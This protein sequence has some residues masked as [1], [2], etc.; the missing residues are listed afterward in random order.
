MHKQR[1]GNTTTWR[2]PAKIEHST[3]KQPDTMDPALQTPHLRDS[4]SL[5]LKELWTLFTGEFQTFQQIKET[6]E[7]KISVFEKKYFL[8]LKGTYLS[9]TQKD[10]CQKKGLL[11][12]LIKGCKSPVF[13]CTNFCLLS[14]KSAI[15]NLYN[16]NKNYCR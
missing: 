3:E 11:Q 7:L 14:K 16:N 2:S 15:L 6:R 9:V 10:K 1:T 12:N 4:M 13:F 8:N 5:K